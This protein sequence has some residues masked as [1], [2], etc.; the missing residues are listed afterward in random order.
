M[1]D[2]NGP[3]LTV[4]EVARATGK[5]KR[6]TLYQLRK[7]QQRFPR[8]MLSFERPGGS[9]RKWFVN[10]RLLERIDRL[11]EDE[12]EAESAERLLQLEEQRDRIEALE[13]KCKALIAAHKVMK[14]QHRAKVQAP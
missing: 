13:A 9:R 3:Y 14:R 11:G 12:V 10:A 8:L 7:L 6:T 1:N 2:A 5:P 4:A